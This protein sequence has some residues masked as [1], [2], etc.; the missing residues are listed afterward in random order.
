M[1]STDEVRRRIEA[2]VSGAY[3]EVVDTTGAGDHFEVRV[4]APPSPASASS[5]SIA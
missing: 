3:A 4:T 1:V 2:G 5:S